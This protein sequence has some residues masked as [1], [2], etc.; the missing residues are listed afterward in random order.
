[1]IDVTLTRPHLIARLAAPLRMLSWAPYRPGF[2]TADT[3]IWREVRN[4]DLTPD[5][6]AIGWLAEQMS[7]LAMPEAV[8]LL[9]SRDIGTY[10]LEQ[11]VSGRSMGQCLA[12]VGLSNA[13]R[14]GSRMPVTA[15]P[16][17]TINLL[18]VTDTALTDTAMIEAL[19]IAAQARTAAVMDAALDLPTGRATGTGTDCIVL[20]CPPGDTG[21]A[22]LHTD[23]GEAIGRAVYRAV[24]AGAQHWMETEA[25]TGHPG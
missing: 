7:A 25:A 23:V 24:V 6:D 22:G 20:A 11:A 2:V 10:R 17:G 9:T 14:I 8:G 5:F 12:T 21:Y 1:M 19:S 18:A 16:T 15:A 13:E 3:V 4:A